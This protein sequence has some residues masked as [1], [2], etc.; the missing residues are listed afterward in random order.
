VWLA[1]EEAGVG[2]V[3][4]IGGV[5]LLLGC[6]CGVPEDRPAPVSGDSEPGVDTGAVYVDQDGDG[7]SPEAGDCDDQDPSVHQ[8]RLESCDGIDNNCN[9]LVD[10]GFGD[11]DGDGTADC[12]D[13]EECDGLDNDGD[14]AVDEGFGDADGDGTVD[15]LDHEDCDGVDNDGDGVVD[16]G[17]DTDG[18]GFV[19]CWTDASPA[20]CDDADPAVNPGADE[21]DGDLTDNDCD[22]MVDELAWAAG[23]L[24][25]SEVMNNPQVV[26]DPQGEWF[27]LVNVSGRELLLVGLTLATESSSLQLGG[28]GPL[29]LPPGGVAVFGVSADEDLNGGVPVDHV[30]GSLGLCNEHGSLSV[31]AG[32]LLI[33]TVSWDD[34]ATM[35]DV[36]GASM[37]LDPW[38]LDASS[39]DEAGCWCAASEGWAWA[40]EQGSPGMDN[41]LCPAL[42]HDGDGYTGVQGD[43][44]DGDPEIHPGA[45]EGWYDGVDQDCDGWSDFDADADGYDSD[46][47]GGLDCDDSDAAVSPSATEVCD[48]ADLDED[49]DGLADDDD[50]SP[51]GTST[52]HF[53]ADLDGYGDASTSS[54]LCD[55]GP[56][57]ISVGG[58]CD[59]SAADSYPG[60][61]EVCGD[62]LDQDCD[63][64]DLLC[65]LFGLDDAA[66]ILIGTEQ[67][68]QL[69]IGVADAGDVDGDGIADLIMGAPYT[70]DAI[71]T[72]EVGRAYLVSGASSALAGGGLSGGIMDLSVSCAW[73]DGQGIEAKAGWSVAGAGDL[74]LDGFDDVLVGSFGDGTVGSKAGAAYLLYGP[75]SGG[76]DPT[77]ADAVLLG[78]LPGAYTGYSL[79]AVEDQDADGYSEVVV[80]A[81]GDSARGSRA[82]AVHLMYGP[83]TG[84]VDLVFSDAEYLGE[85]ADHRAG[86]S[87]ADL[88]DVDGDGRSDLAVGAYGYDNGSTQ[89]GASYILT[90]THS[91]RQSLAVAQAT[92]EGEDDGDWAG[93]RVAA[94]GDMDGDGLGDLLVGATNHGDPVAGT[95]TVYL[96]CS[97]PTG[98]VSLAAAEAKFVG[99]LDSGQLGLGMAGGND[100]DGDGQLDLLL[101]DSRSENIGVGGEVYLVLGPVSGV[102]SL[103]DDSAAIMVGE[104]ADE[105]AGI[106]LALLGDQDSD[107]LEEIVVG[108]W[109]SDRGTRDGGAV[110]VVAGASLF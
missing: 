9:G 44:D 99:D 77:T 22:G 89:P 43:C 55:P 54:D 28:Q 59:D 108:A 60:A 37:S 104:Q 39:N 79:T 87:V 3:G 45:V 23:D 11:G 56:G 12:V 34:G 14:G 41:Q 84:T 35:P 67:Y 19:E 102:V 20:D 42:D 61:S 66:T 48:P 47:H 13:H 86:A 73:F 8:G 15:C 91:G 70:E 51:T 30:S 18:D 83:L 85:A 46:E 92:L 72:S 33:D 4:W 78:T 98:V 75:L 101:A 82:G 69:G 110:Y 107:G 109:D 1:P 40:S 21:Q 16:E 90:G 24:V 94:A 93:Y 76:Y 64:V 81:Y 17:Y 96:Q 71:G 6:A 32:D 53:D 2:R 49:C 26:A 80:G 57:W 65:G 36:A 10:E 88:G 58:D 105:R 95:G 63:G 7:Y 25:I 38:C 103:L 97:L 62:G 29:P 5:L 31:L 50:P 106:G 100:F 52:Y 27:E 74:D 68:G